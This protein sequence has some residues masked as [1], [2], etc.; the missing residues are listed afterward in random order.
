MSEPSGTIDQTIVQL[1]AKAWT[2]PGFKASLLADPIPVLAAEGIAVPPGITVRI[3]E[4]TEQVVNFV[5]PQ[6][7]VSHELSDEDLEKV[8]GGGQ[9]QTPELQQMTQNLKTVGPFTYQSGY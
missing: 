7:P 2:D 3:L 8:A 9:V 4:N 1:I 6:P 5:L